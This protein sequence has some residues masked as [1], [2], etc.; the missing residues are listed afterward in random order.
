MPSRVLLDVRVDLGVGA[1]E[2]GVRDQAGAAV[3]R[4]DDVDHVQVALADQ[5]VPVHVEKIQS[6]RG[7]PVAQQARLHVVQGQG[8]LEQGIVFQVDL[9]D[10]KIV[11]RAP[12]G[13][14]LVSISTQGAIA[15]LRIWSLRQLR[16]SWG[17]PRG[18]GC[19]HIQG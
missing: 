18:K 3:T 7:A 16:L 10:G 19:V 1:F 5:P 4:A 9:A 14:H 6:G 11:G 12:I 17:A 2:I 8:P 13:I 15:L